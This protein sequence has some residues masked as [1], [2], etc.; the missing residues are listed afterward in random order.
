M[1]CWICRE[2]FNLFILKWFYTVTILP[3]Q[4]E[5][6]KN[7]NYSRIHVGKLHCNIFFVLALFLHRKVLLYKHWH[8]LWKFKVLFRAVFR[9]VS[10]I[11][12]GAFSAKRINDF[13]LFTAA[14]KSSITGAG[15]CRK[16]MLFCYFYYRF[17]RFI[18][19]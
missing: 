3:L 8:V 17:G 5:P 13:Y 14:K 16:C 11:Y 6:Y 7:R 9:T 4:L 18:Y 2:T 15:Q 19:Y 12:D 1:I 10:S